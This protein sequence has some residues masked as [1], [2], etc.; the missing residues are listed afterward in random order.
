MT[1]SKTCRSRGVSVATCDLA[2]RASVH[3]VKMS[4]LDLMENSS[5]VHD[6]KA[7]IKAIIELFA[8]D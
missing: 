1:R 8:R 6:Y 5:V 2:R 3:T 7:A 4:G